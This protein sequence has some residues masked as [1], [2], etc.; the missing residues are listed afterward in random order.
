[1]PKGTISRPQRYKILGDA[2]C[3]TGVEAMSPCPQCR[4]SGAVCFVKKGYKKC[5]PCTSKNVPCDGTFSKSSF[6][7]LEKKKLELQEKSRAGRRLM[8]VFMRQ[9][10]AQE[11]EVADIEQRLEVIRKRQD[12]MVDREARALGELDEMADSSEPDQEVMALEDDFF[13]FDDPDFL[14]YGMVVSSETSS[15]VVDSS[16]GEFQVPKCFRSQGN[17]STS[18]GNG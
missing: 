12:V 1:M 5:G 6:D 17:P 7:T 8:K 9:L 15:R 18:S 16:G 14:S 3:K 4:R 10:M 11:K 2:I 13:L